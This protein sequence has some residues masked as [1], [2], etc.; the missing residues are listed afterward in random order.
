LNP[1]KDQKGQILGAYLALTISRF[2]S[3][4]WL[5]WSRDAHKK[6][7]WFF[8]GANHPFSL[9]YTAKSGLFGTFVKSLRE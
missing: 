7:E 5:P 1:K 9:V 3:R 8:C 6:A 4:R 2:F